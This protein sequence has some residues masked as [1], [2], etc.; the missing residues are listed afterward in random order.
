MIDAAAF[1]TLHMLP[2]FAADMPPDATRRFFSPLMFA[3]TRRCHAA[4]MLSPCHIIIFS[5]LLPMLSRC[6]CCLWR[7]TRV[8]YAADA[9]AM[10]R[11][12]L[13]MLPCCF[14]FADAASC[15]R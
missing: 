6:R 5:L 1:V 9:A 2:R 10:P 4:A 13:L 12:L 3:A 8:Y 15:F 7:A 14:S 11:L